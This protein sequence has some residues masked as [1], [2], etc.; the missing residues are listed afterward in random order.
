[1]LS[2]FLYFI[3]HAKGQSKRLL[4]VNLLKNVLFS[5]PDFFMCVFLLGCSRQPQQYGPCLGHIK[6]IKRPGQRDAQH[7]GTALGNA[8]AQASFFIAQYQ[9]GG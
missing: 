4:V 8:R 1:M 2:C 5:G 9:D 3:L 7:S 6:R